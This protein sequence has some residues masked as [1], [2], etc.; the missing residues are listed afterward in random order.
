MINMV[1]IIMA[2]IIMTIIIKKSIKRETKK[3]PQS[4]TINEQVLFI[5]D[6]L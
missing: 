6:F 1:I 3:D 2:T 4:V 5:T